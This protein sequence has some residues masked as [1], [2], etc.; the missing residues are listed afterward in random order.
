MHSA[1]A[2]VV[3]VR[4]PPSLVCQERPQGPH[5]PRELPSEK[6]R[7]HNPVHFVVRVN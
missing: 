6:I 3:D 7:R 1:V 2:D 5:A 4:F